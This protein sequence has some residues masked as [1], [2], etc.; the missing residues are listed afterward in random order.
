MIILVTGVA[1]SGKTTLGRQLAE[2][3]GW[4]FLEGDWLHPPKNI[5]KM[6]SG[7]PLSDRDREPW[8]ALL[9]R[10]IRAGLKEGRETVVACSLLKEA[11]RRYLISDHREVR[12][13]FLTGEPEIIRSRMKNRPDH[14]MPAALLDSQFADLEEPED[15]VI[16]DISLSCEDAVAK[17]LKSFELS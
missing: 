5:E 7:I 10:A 4:E 13:V 14:F 11:Y 9:D 12:L 17:V 1:G 8:L 15:A 3:L 2:T 6:R 16:V